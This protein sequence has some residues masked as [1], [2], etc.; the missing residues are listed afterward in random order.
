MI[1]FE[2]ET[3]V[4]IINRGPSFGLRRIRRMRM[5]TKLDQQ[6]ANGVVDGVKALISEV[7]RLEGQVEIKDAALKEMMAAYE[8]RIRSDCTS[9]SALAAQPWRCAEFCQAERALAGNK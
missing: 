7:E 9:Q 2:D 4:K 5:G 6:F 3:P 8:R 1:E